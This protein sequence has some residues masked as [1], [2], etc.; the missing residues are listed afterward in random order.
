MQTPERLIPSLF[1]CI[2]EGYDLKT[3]RQDIIAGLTVAIVALP[4]AM[5]MAVA[6]G[7]SPDK[8][9]VT[10]VVAGFFISFLGGTRVQIGGPTGAFVVV[11]FD[12][13]AR[14]GFDGLI[15]ASVMAG[16]LLI[17]AGYARLGKL[18][19][20][21]P[22]PVITGFTTGI[23]VIIAS[24]QVKD[25]LG[26]NFTDV[27]AEFIEKWMAYFKHLDETSIYALGLGLLGFA[28]IAI[29]KKVSAKI[30][31]YLVSIV[32]VSLIA[33]LFN[34]PVDTIGSRF[35]QM[36]N[37]LPMPTLPSLTLDEIRNLIPSAFTIA[38]L[39]GIEALLSAV[40]ADSMTGYKHSL[41]QELI[42]QGV[43]NI[44]SGFFG[45][46]P[47]T[48]AI[49][50]TATNIKSGGK[51]PISGIFHALFLLVFLYTIMDILAYIPMAGLAAV[52]F[53]VAWGMSDIK[54][55]VQI[56]KISPS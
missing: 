50:R 46:L 28:I 18:I 39:A 2:Q 51:T 54:H 8:G 42:G 37:G 53:M 5:A 13:I 40:V 15:V 27:P 29:S 36:P 35:P 3:F 56:S 25:F 16:I 22:Y 45:G 34:L 31:A 43:A 19:K 11:I 12:V 48:G 23:A 9:L 4:L 24:S 33:F 41:N 32:A 38:F 21:I 30:P 6:S 17:V 55:F 52:L 44:A 14:Y 49:A 20:Y 47:A 26:L 10:A 1:T 7:A